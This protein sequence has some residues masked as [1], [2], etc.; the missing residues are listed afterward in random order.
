[1]IDGLIIL[2]V[3]VLLFFAMKGSV[4]H[5]KGEGACCS[6]GSSLVKSGEKA[7]SG[8][9]VAIRLVTIGGM[10]CANCAERVKRAVDSIDGA[11]C[12]VDLRNSIATVK[13]DRRI[14]DI[15]IKRKIEE[16][17]YTVS[18]IKQG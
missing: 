9:V 16:A 14:D 10:H 11:S 4:K 13:M 6:G 12:S 8:P 15:T 2:I 5:F 18:S 1:M 3:I 17:G 7:L